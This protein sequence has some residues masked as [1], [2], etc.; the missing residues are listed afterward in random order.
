[1]A[2][3]ISDLGMW[4]DGG[5]G[6]VMS[7]LDFAAKFQS[8]L[9]RQLFTTN[10]DSLFLNATKVTMDSNDKLMS[11][12]SE[13]SKVNVVDRAI[14][15]VDQVIPRSRSANND[16]SF[17]DE[18]ANSAVFSRTTDIEKVLGVG[19]DF[20]SVNWR[21]K[22]YKPLDDITIALKNINQIAIGTGLNNIETILK[23]FDIDLMANRLA[24]I[25]APD[26][27]IGGILSLHGS[28]ADLVKGIE[29]V[30]ANFEGLG[31]DIIKASVIPLTARATEFV[32]E[33][34]Q[35][36]V[37]ENLA[38]VN[39]AVSTAITSGR[40]VERSSKRIQKVVRSIINSLKKVADSNEVKYTLLFLQ[41][42][43]MTYEIYSAYN[44]VAHPAA[45]EEFVQAKF[46]EQQKRSRVDQKKYEAGQKE[47]IAL[48]NEIRES[49]PVKHK[50]TTVSTKC[51]LV[52]EP[53]GRSTVIVNL[54]ALVNVEV[55]C[56]ND[57]WLNVCYRPDRSEEEFT[58]W[59][60]KEYTSEK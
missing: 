29:T 33:H 39:S 32:I 4:S 55:L 44:D 50:T 6:K 36:E 22:N 46:Q 58:G 21:I 10:F 18:L 56:G 14:S 37:L 26:T 42:V 23:P 28:S 20:N 51:K 31:L 1:M 24:S 7:S 11:M 59:I 35:W 16:L 25:N 49:M 27:A 15:R 53:K 2:K 45:T 47:M 38:K 40:T 43:L 52:T 30:N 41:V 5:L 19:N 48:L 13:A 9:D 54:P 57:K 3:R 17:F 34:K 60:L 8:K 12:L